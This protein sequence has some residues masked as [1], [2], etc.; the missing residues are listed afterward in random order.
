MICALT[1]SGK[2]IGIAAN[3]HK[4]IRNLLD[5][6]IVAAKEDGM[7]INCAQKPLAWRSRV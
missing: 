7:R 6:V 5:E 4:V 1:R 2:R 3:S